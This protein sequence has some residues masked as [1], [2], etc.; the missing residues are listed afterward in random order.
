MDKTTV[1]ELRLCD[2]NA[3]NFSVTVNSENVADIR[4][5]SR[6]T[7]PLPLGLSFND[8][9][10]ERW[11]E[12][13]AIPYNRVNADKLCIQMG[14]NPS[15]TA[16]IVEVS[17]GLS[18]NDSY[19]VVPE[20]FPGKFND[21]NLFE[22]DFSKILS[23]VAYTGK[24]DKAK[25]GSHGLTPELA[26]GGSLP[27]A[28]RIDRYGRRLLYKGKTESYSVGEPL[29]ES[30]VSA[31]ADAAG[32]DHARYWLDDWMNQTCSVCECFC[33]K[34]VSYVPFAVATGKTSLADAVATMLCLDASLF[35]E[36][37]DMLMLDCVCENTDRHLTNFGFLYQPG[38]NSIIDLA[39]IFDNGRALFPNIEN[40]ELDALQSFK[41]TY[42]PA[43]GAPT[44]NDLAKRLIGD[45]QKEW[46]SVIRHSDLVTILQ[47]AGLDAFR[48][49]VLSSFVKEQCN[50]LI[51]IP[52][53]SRSEL[54]AV[55]LSY[56]PDAIEFSERYGQIFKNENGS[57]S[58][59]HTKSRNENA[60][61]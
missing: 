30:A 39:P 14:V 53:V 56:F 29:S 15:N 49:K 4:V 32:L 31:I 20:G 17:R 18:L 21:Y 48:A 57:D 43:F 50:D 42:A 7:A 3:L 55:S 47:K 19:W 2:E 41:D 36:F 45:K 9:S 11:L 25:I 16:R 60:I 40:S 52:S 12:T 54:K 8:A 23:I 10:L 34:T 1:F 51:E 46:L 22:N 58:Q 59:D 6:G 24:L 44:F 26:T 38:T 37:V 33:T 61:D 35:E 28:W 13:R 27:K 5:I